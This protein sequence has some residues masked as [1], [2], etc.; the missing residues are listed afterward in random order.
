MSVLDLPGD[1][2]RTDL[3]ISYSMAMAVPQDFRGLLIIRTLLGAAESI[4]TPAFALITARFYTR[5][6]QPLRFAIWYS[7]NGL[8]S[9]IGGLLGYGVGFINNTKIYSWA[10][11]FILNGLI[12]VLA[13]CGFFL[14]CPDSPK[15]ARFLTISEREVALERVR[16]NQSSIRSYKT[17]VLQARVS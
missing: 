4:V 1:G 9:M 10:W 16:A 5:D 17:S 6:E 2:L 8:G 14:L 15:E 13:G 11:I 12:T 3:F 7:C